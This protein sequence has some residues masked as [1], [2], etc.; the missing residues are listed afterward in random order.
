MQLTTDALKHLF[1]NTNP[2]LRLLR[3]IGLGATN[4]VTPLKRM[5]ARHALN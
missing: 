1:V 2:L 4:A 5:L 3:N